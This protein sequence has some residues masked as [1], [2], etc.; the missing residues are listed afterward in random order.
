MD[1]DSIGSEIVLHPLSHPAADRHERLGPRPDDLSDDLSDYDDS[2]AH[3]TNSATD[4]DDTPDNVSDIDGSLADNSFGFPSPMFA[5]KPSPPHL[6]LEQVARSDIAP[7]FRLW[8]G[9]PY[10]ARY[11]SFFRSP[12]FASVI[13]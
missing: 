11:R 13:R 5:S 6:K 9:R 8:M 7:G 3:D 10:A 2:T 1:S 4:I 12:C